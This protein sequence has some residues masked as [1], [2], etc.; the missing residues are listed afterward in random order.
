MVYRSGADD[1]PGYGADM[2][3]RFDERE[4]MSLAGVACFEGL[5]AGPHWFAAE[6]YDEAI[7]DSVRGSKLLDVTTRAALYEEVMQ[8]S[9][10]H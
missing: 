5:G 6:G 8:V 1:F 3:A 9:E 10:V 2:D 7:R 4:E